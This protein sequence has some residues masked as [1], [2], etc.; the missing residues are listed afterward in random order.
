MN[1]EKRLRYAFV[2]TLISVSHS[3]NL[4]IAVPSIF[5]INQIQKCRQYQENSVEICSSYGKFPYFVSW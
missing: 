5:I 4:C 3:W 1:C 2:N